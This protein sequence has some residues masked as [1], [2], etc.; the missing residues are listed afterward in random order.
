VQP[1]NLIFF[2]EMG[3]TVLDAALRQGFN[4][5]YG[6]QQG[7]CGTC[8]AKLVEGKISYPGIDPIGLE[9]HEADE[10]FILLCGA[11]PESDIVLRHAGVTAPWQFPVKKINYRVT[12][13]NTL[14]PTVVQVLLEPTDADFIH[15]QA[16]QYVQVHTK[17]NESRPFS[18]ANAPTSDNKIELHIRH[19][20]DNAFS[21]ELLSLITNKQPI[22]LEGPFGHCVYRTGLSYPLIFIA[23]GTGFAHTKAIIEQ[24]ILSAPDTPMHLFWGAKTADDLYMNHLPLE[25]QKNLTNFHYTPT[26]SKSDG[27]FNWEGHTVSLPTLMTTLYPDLTGKLIY[28]SGPLPLVQ[29][30]IEQGKAHGLKTAYFF[31]DLMP[32]CN[33]LSKEECS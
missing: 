6:C 18:I 33:P 17:N 2:V 13:V 22:E 29:D 11:V 30:T 5:S 31:S 10:N 24:T 15:F 19:T 26:L 9:D 27:S 14:S 4:F 28:T 1:E 21:T 7:A 23:G 3:E 25:W 8:A 12:S 32:P 16:G 20:D